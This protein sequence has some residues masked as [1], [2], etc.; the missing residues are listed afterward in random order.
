[1]ADSP[2]IIRQWSLLRSL[3]ARRFGVSTRELA[4]EHTVNERTIRRDLASLREAGF[5]IEERTIENGRKLW[6]VS[7]DSGF[8]DLTLNLTEVLSLYVGRKLMEPLAGTLFWQGTHSSYQ[9][10]RAT[11]ADG[12][13]KYL[14]RL[15]ALVSAHG[16]GL[17]VKRRISDV[18]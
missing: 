10:I 1:M 11:L 6:L 14:N 5:P 7:K 17:S 13:I 18:S 9:K 15:S 16:I 3:A 4:E 8:G 2:Q 12:G